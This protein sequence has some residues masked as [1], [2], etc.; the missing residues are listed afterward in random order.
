MLNW[1]VHL[2]THYQKEWQ[3]LLTILKLKEILLESSREKEMYQ[4]FLEAKQEYQEE[5]RRM[6]I[7]EQQLERTQ[8]DSK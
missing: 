7:L 1:R 5:R 2:Y 3:Y 4:R 6:V 8:L